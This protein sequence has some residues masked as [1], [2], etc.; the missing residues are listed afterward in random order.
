MVSSANKI[1]LQQ[2]KRLFSEKHL[3]EEANIVY[4]FPF[5]EDG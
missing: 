3:F 5:L 4:N 2:E 1:Q